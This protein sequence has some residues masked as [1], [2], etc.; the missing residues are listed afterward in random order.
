M[1]TILTDLKKLVPGRVGDVESF[2]K[3]FSKLVSYVHSPKFEKV[4]KGLIDSGDVKVEGEHQEKA[5]VAAPVVEAP[6]APVVE[7][8]SPVVAVEPEVKV[9]E[10][11]PQAP[12]TVEAPPAPVAPAVA[13][14]VAEKSPFK[15]KR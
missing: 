13:E 11:V 2:N 1:A 12:E 3:A 5:V 7:V 14:P 6:P 8:V 15:K 4:L 10:A 9:E